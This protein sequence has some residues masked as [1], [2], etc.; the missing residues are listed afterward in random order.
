MFLKASPCVNAEKLNHLNDYK[1]RK[2]L[3]AGLCYVTWNTLWHC[4]LSFTYDAELDVNKKEPFT[5]PVQNNCGK[6]RLL[7][8]KVQGCERQQAKRATDVT[9]LMKSP[10]EPNDFWLCY[11]SLSQPRISGYSVPALNRPCLDMNIASYFSTNQ[12]KS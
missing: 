9:S 11:H 6:I 10:K 4:P 7:P 12:N 1:N 3:P 8:K 5:F 2:M